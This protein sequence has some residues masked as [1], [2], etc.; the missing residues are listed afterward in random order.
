MNVH[1]VYSSYKNRTEFISVQIPPRR[2]AARWYEPGLNGEGRSKQ[3]AIP[4]HF[5]I[6]DKIHRAEL[7]ADGDYDS[8]FNVTYQMIKQG[9]TL[10]VKC[11]PQGGFTVIL[12]EI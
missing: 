10:E 11:L 2:T 5:R 6:K 7:I 8:G 3:V 9:D 12:N 1:P 4:F